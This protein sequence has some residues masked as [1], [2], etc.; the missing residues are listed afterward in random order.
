MRRIKRAAFGG[1]RSRIIGL[2]AGAAVVT[3]CQ[4]VWAPAD[5][6]PKAPKPLVFSSPAKDCFRD[7]HELVDLDSLPAADRAIDAAATCER[8]A[9]NKKNGR[10]V[11]NSYARF[12]AAKAMRIIYERQPNLDPGSQMLKEAERL[13]TAAS[14]A[15]P[16]LVEGRLEL[17][18]VHR[19]QARFDVADQELNEIDRSGAGGESAGVLFEHAMAIIGNIERGG[20]ARRASGF[21]GAGGAPDNRDAI[22]AQRVT[23]LGYLRNIRPQDAFGDQYVRF[24][25]PLELARLAN[26]LGETVMKTLPATTGNVEQAQ[27]R[28]VDARQAVEQLRGQGRWDAEW[29]K[30]SPRIYFN[31]GRANLRMSGILRNPESDNAECAP[32]R[33]GRPVDSQS[34]RALS[35]AE[36]NFSLAAAA[37]D[38]SWGLGCVKMARGDVTGALQNFQAAIAQPSANSALDPWDAYL[39]QARAQAALGR[40]PDAV[41]SYERALAQNPAGS[42]TSQVQME[43]AQ[44]LTE[45]GRKQEA[46]DRIAKVLQTPASAKDRFDPKYDPAQYQ[47]PEAYI[48]RALIWI[49]ALGRNVDGTVDVAPGADVYHARLNLEEA[50]ALGGLVPGRASYMLS[51]LEQSQGRATAAVQAADDAVQADRSQARYRR[52]ACLMRI[53]FWTELTTTLRERGALHCAA[54]TTENAYDA[55]EQFLF[56]GMFHMRGTF[57]PAT[58][59]EQTRAWGDALNAFTLGINRL[60]DPGDVPARLQLRARL[61]RGQNDALVCGGYRNATDAIA[62]PRGEAKDAAMADDFFKAYGLA[63]CAPRRS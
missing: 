41:A 21:G 22:Q 38:A 51:L 54:G 58:G 29:Q 36:A 50:A 52:Q 46:L 34:A 27:S 35:E 42:T 20:G 4:S 23:A 2:L 5:A 62:A 37:G 24:R 63:L 53:R 18:R 6:A 47:N 60:G 31:L 10:D 26:D 57:P 59:G 32:S 56:Q 61:A 14:S 33:P 39:G 16:K 49:P 1:L 7:P 19:L 44:T 15:N 3:A 43:L 45:A 30:L 11:E 25:A 17:A 9:L 8:E 40:I 55:A 48:Q 13:F 12:F 28:F